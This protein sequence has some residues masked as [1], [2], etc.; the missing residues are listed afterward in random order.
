MRDYIRRFLIAGII[1]LCV[2]LLFLGGKHPSA[3]TISESK[4]TSQWIWPADGE[5]SDIFGTRK[6]MHKGIDIAADLGTP[7]YTVDGGIVT[8]SY[9]SDT[10]GNVIFIK[11]QNNF[12]TVYAHLKTRKVAEGQTVRQGEFIGEM[13]NTGDSSGVHLHFEVHR[14][15]WTYGKEN[16]VNPEMAFGTSKIGQAV[17]AQERGNSL[18][19]LE[20]SGSITE[21]KAHK[22]PLDKE[23]SNNGQAIS[24]IVRNG[25]TLWSIARQYD[26]SVEAIKQKNKLK[27]N[28]I[29]INQTLVVPS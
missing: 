12:E 1:A 6:G 23:S 29:R 18:A 15:E 5:I 19:S 28:F 25:E 2:S 11:H 20:T 24:H 27:N 13:G 14:H 3:Q 7:V 26:S 21:E 16:A 4:G 9:Y 8:R 10:Y 17:A 22:K